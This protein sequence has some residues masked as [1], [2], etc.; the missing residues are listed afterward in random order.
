MAGKPVK[1]LAACLSPFCSLIEANLCAC[2]DGGL[3]VL[4]S[5]D[6]NAKHVDWNLRLSTRRG[7]SWVT[8]TPV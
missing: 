8:G 7:N 6:L 2:F 5:G 4:M 1:I 3:T